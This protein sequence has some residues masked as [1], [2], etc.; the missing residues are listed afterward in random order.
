M[1]TMF[2]SDFDETF[3]AR[4]EACIEAIRIEAESSGDP[5]VLNKRREALRARAIELDKQ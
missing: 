5:D 2:V 1:K 4:A 3:T